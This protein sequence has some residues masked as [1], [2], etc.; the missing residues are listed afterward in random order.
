MSLRAP[1]VLISVLSAPAVWTQTVISAHS[2]TVNYVEGVVQLAGQPVKLNGV[3]FPEVKIGQTLSTQIGHAEILLTPR[4]FLRLGRNTSFRMIS[5]KLTNP[6]VEI[7]NGSAIVDY[8]ILLQNR[9]VNLDRIVVRMGDSETLILKAGRYYFDADAGHISVFDGKAHVSGA[10]NTTE[11]RGG[12][13]LSVGA[14]LT[15]EKL[16]RKKSTDELYT[17]SVRRDY[18]LGISA[19]RGATSQRFSTRSFDLGG[20][21]GSVPGDSLPCEP[22]VF[23]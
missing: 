9:S 6:F 19:T 12:R 23:R 17:W 11:I 22:A 1:A 13:A 7:L 18:V 21:P 10:S 20:C 16:N 2:G 15:P 8:D 3:S 4:V 5:N 14:V